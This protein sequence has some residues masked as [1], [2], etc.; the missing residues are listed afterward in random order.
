MDAPCSDLESEMSKIDEKLEIAKERLQA[1]EQEEY[2]EELGKSL[3]RSHLESSDF[4]G[5]LD[6]SLEEPETVAPW[7][8]RSNGFAKLC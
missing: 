8:M 2:L 1:I 7:I 6:T 3:N 5:E 4:K